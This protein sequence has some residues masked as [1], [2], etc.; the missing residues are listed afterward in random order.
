MSEGGKW[1]HGHW[2]NVNRIGSWA[3]LSEGIKIAEN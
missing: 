1:A 3:E 2:G